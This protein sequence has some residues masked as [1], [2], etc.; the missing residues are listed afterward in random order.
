MNQLV[1]KTRED[2]ANIF[3]ETAELYGSAP[4]RVEV[5]GN[6]TDYNDGFA[7]AAAIDR[8]IAVVGRPIPGDTA[9]IY[10]L[11]FKAGSSF[12]VDN[13]EPGSGEHW[14][15]Y[16]MGVVWRLRK[17]GHRVGAFEAVVA[18]DVP[19]GAGLSSSAAMEMAMGNFLKAMAGFEMAPMDMALNCRAAE[20]D[21]VGV[22]CGILDQWTSA[23]GRAG[24]LLLLDCRKHEVLVYVPL[25]DHLALVIAD[26]AAPH[27]LLA[28]DYNRRRESCLRAA[29]ICA[30]NLTGKKV[31]HLRDISMAEFESC[32]AA[33]S[34]EDFRRARH[35]VGENARTLAG[36]KALA[37][38]DAAALGRLFTESHDSS[39]EN[40]ENSG[41]ELDAMVAAAAG[42]P[43]WYGS[44]LTGGGFG[45]AT[46]NLVE[47]TAA[48][49]FG[50][51]LKRRYLAR[52]G[53]EPAIHVL[54]PSNGAVG[55]RF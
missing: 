23:M 55:G 10:S 21:F 28:G 46:V 38:G 17:I 41:P 9:R 40:F 20:N 43:G 30:E 27:T 48:A 50:A 29:R 2:F 6:H 18:G 34:D 36:E 1:E 5:L 19:L 35:V 37:A 47:A 53:L 52:T 8:S 33:M 25:P 22:Q 32:Q 31:T 45:G 39:R 51:E 14:L 24:K 4:G 49:G 16:L 44:R 3:G 42:L 26:T 13:P 15:N 7:L 11:T 54:K 12:P